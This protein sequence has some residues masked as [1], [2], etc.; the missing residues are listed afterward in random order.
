M[1]FKLKYPYSKE[2]KHPMAFTGVD[3]QK[4][5]DSGKMLKSIE[6]MTRPVKKFRTDEVYFSKEEYSSFDGEKIPYYLFAPKIKKEKYPAMIYYHGGGFMFPIQKSMMKNSVIYAKE[7]G[8]KV[9][10]PDMR[11][12]LQH[13]CDTIL[14]DCYGMLK[15]IFEHAEELGVD[16]EKIFVYGDSAGGSLAAS[17]TQLCRDRDGYKLC[18]QLLCYPV[19]DCESEKYKSVE[20]YENAPWSKNANRAMWHTFLRKGTDMPQYVVPMRNNLHGLPKAYIEPLEI[21]VLKDEALAYAAK[22]RAA[23]V[24]V[25]ENLI[26]GAYHGYDADLKSPLVKRSFAARMKFMREILNAKNVMGDKK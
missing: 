9:F 15:Y 21:D 24:E 22:L 4:A 25:V 20:E 6:F 5:I 17:V 2:L 10:L 14:E 13:P 23:D 7:M 26:P 18:G 3:M 11:I 19:L 16:I 12:S 1:F 8:I